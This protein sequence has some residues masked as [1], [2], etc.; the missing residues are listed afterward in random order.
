MDDK[1]RN[2]LKKGALAAVGLG[3]FAAAS[4]DTARRM[5]RGLR[6]GTAGVPVADAEHKNSLVPEYRI[7]PEGHAAPVKG[8]RVA[9]NSA[10]AVPPSAACACIST[11]QRTAWYGLRAILTTLCPPVISC[12]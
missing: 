4:L 1:K 8:Q 5:V 7:N 9:F 12:P 11:R 6:E 10:G 3:V 2:F